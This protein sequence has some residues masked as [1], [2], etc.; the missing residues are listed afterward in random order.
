MRTADVLLGR[1]IPG[2]AIVLAT[3]ALVVVLA[4]RD[5]TVSSDSGAAEKRLANIEE[6]LDELCTKLDSA[7]AQ[8]NKPAEATEAAVVHSKAEVK[9]DLR[10]SKPLPEET[11][12]PVLARRL[13]ADLSLTDTQIDALDRSLEEC[14][15]SLEALGKEDDKKRA[16]ALGR[17]ARSWANSL[18]PPH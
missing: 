15:R 18:R 5:S 1:M 16:E 8:P 14:A 4:G 7:T 9:K 3:A 12:W 6:K 10:S 17:R 11:P 13:T 2:V